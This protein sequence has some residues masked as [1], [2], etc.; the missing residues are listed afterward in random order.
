MLRLLK[1]KRPNTLTT[2]NV[3]LSNLLI[4]SCYWFHISSCL[5]IYVLKMWN[6]FRGVIVL[7]FAFWP[8][9]PGR[10]T[11]LNAAL[12]LFL[13]HSNFQVCVAQVQWTFEINVVGLFL[14]T[15]CRPPCLSTN[16]RSSKMHN[17]SD[18]NDLLV[19]FV[20]RWWPTVRVCSFWIK[21]I[22]IRTRADRSDPFEHG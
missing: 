4:S 14:I 22:W 19:S 1:S 5:S 7:R 9:H 17:R 16:G 20:I 15:N 11:S 3:Q 12:I 13:F 6:V 21:I 2:R 8:Q 10:R 18:P